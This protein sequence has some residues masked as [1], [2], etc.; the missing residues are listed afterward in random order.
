MY[1]WDIKSEATE[2]HCLETQGILEE[3]STLLKGQSTL[4]YTSRS[5]IGCTKKEV[6]SLLATV[7]LYLYRAAMDRGNSCHILEYISKK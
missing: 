4:K 2:L 3:N 7:H 1:A 6:C 5:L